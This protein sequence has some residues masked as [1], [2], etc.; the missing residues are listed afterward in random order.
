MVLETWN[1]GRSKNLEFETGRF[2]SVKLKTDMKIQALDQKFRD[3]E[4][5]KKKVEFELK[6]DDTKKKELIDKTRKVKIT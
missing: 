3:S 6:N 5:A 2:K 1:S 4:E